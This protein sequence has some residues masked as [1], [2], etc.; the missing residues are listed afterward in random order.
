MSPDARPS[1]R[2]RSDTVSVPLSPAAVYRIP[3]SN[4]GAV[5]G[6]IAATAGRRTAVG[7]VHASVNP[8]AADTSTASFTHCRSRFVAV[9]AMLT[10]RNNVNIFKYCQAKCNKQL[11]QELANP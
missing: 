2:A 10:F 1:A 9:D 7:A 6:S 11:R 8:T 4:G 3:Y 5:A